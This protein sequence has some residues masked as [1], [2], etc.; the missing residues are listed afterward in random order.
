[1]ENL[2]KNRV[3]I[4]IAV[5]AGLSLLSYYLPN[6]AGWKMLFIMWIPGLAAII[7]ALSTGLSFRTMGWKLPVKW[8]GAGWL[9]PVVYAFLAYGF[10]WLTGLGDVPNPTFL[11]RARFTMGMSFGNDMLIIISAFFYITILNLI[12]NLIFAMGEELGWRG[13]LVPELSKF[14]G[15]KVTALLSGLVWLGW[16]LPGVINGNYGNTGVPLY[17][18]IFCFGILIMAGSVIFTW[19]RLRSK[20][21]WPAVVLHATHNGVIQAFFERLTLDN[22]NTEYYSGEFGIVLPLISLI[23]ALILL[24]YAKAPNK[25]GRPAQHTAYSEI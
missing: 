18:Q 15:F 5:L 3:F 22:G 10:I 13:F 23:I 11:E 8:I 14:T 24:K 20:S 19:I 4:F 25:I 6:E 17:Y 2:A 12:P 9:I 21:I 7:T 1:M 16:H